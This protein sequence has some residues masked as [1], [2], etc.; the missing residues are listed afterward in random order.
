[1]LHY[2][3]QHDSDSVQTE[4]GALMYHFTKVKNFTDLALNFL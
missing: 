1:M 3:N 4:A 2:T